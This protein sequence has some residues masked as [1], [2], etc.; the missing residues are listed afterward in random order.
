KN[1]L[2]EMDELR[3]SGQNAVFEQ[4]D[5]LVGYKF[6]S[7]EL[8]QQMLSTFNEQVITLIFKS[9]IEAPED[10]VKQSQ[11]PKRDDFSKM[12]ARHNQNLETQR[13][14]ATKGLSTN[15]NEEGEER[16]LTRRERRA[17]Q[18]GKKRK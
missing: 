7:Y 14:A 15:S 18:G 11:A 17:Q 16:P 12:K 10:K 3:T 13:R 6:E 1:H 4:K 2:R 5:P 9:E 8:F